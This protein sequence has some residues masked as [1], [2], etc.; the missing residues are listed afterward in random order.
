MVE[1]TQ[2]SADLLTVVGQGDLSPNE[3]FEAFHRFLDSTPT[4]RVLLDFS[5]ASL[6]HIDGESMRQL[7][8]RVGQAVKERRAHGKAAIVC[9]RDVDYG[10]ARMFS[11][12]VSLEWQPVKFAVFPGANSARAWLDGEV[13]YP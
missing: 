9:S 12:Q 2:T 7:G 13:P 10:M 1:L 6:A 4:R 3:L 11:I 5:S 8:R